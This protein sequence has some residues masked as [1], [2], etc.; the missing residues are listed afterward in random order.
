VNA[1]LSS[2]E[3]SKSDPGLASLLDSGI[4]LKKHKEVQSGDGEEEDY[5]IKAFE[6]ARALL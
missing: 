2:E 3:L 5:P 4:A 6:Q 1:I